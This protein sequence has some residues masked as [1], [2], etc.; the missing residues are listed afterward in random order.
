MAQT[1]CPPPPPQKKKKKKK[2]NRLITRYITHGKP[3]DTVPDSA[4]FSAEI[5][6]TFKAMEIC[7]KSHLIKKKHSRAVI[8]YE[9]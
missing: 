4:M 6:S 9:N 5:K 1:S 8:L 7:L 3:H 2:K